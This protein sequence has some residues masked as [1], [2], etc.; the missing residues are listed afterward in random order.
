MPGQVILHLTD[1]HFGSDPD[2]SGQAERKIVLDSLIEEVACLH[3][4]WKPS[5]VCVTGDIGWRGSAADYAL[6]EAWLRRLLD[7]LGLTFADV[8]VCAGNHDIDRH[9][10]SYFSRPATYAEADQAMRVPIAE[11][12]LDCFSEYT[13]FCKRVQVRGYAFNNHT[14]Y[15][16]GQLDHRGIRFVALNSAWFCRGDDDK[17]RLW[18]GL[19]HLRKMEADGQLQKTNESP[20][21]T[22]A[23]VHHS[24]DWW[25]EEETSTYGSR[26]NTR[27]YLGCRCHLILSGHTHDGIRKADRIA[28]AAY[29][30]TGGAAYAGAAHFNSFRLIRIDSDGLTYR[31]LEFDPR[32]ADNKWTDYGTSTKLPFGNQPSSEALPVQTE[33]SGTLDLASLRL[34]SARDARTVVE[35]KSRQIRPV[36]NLPDTVALGVSVRVTG[37]LDRYDAQGRLEEYGDQFVSLPLYEACRQSRRTVLLG[38]LGSG[39]STLGAQFVVESLDKN[40]NGSAFFIP[41]KALQLPEPFRL[42]ELVSACG[43]YIRG[44]II[45]HLSAFDLESRLTSQVEVALVIDGLDE[46]P[47]PRAAS[48]LRQL[49]ALVDCWPNAQVLATG[50]PIELAGISYENWGLAR[51]NR[52]SDATKRAIF[53]AEALAEGYSLPE[54]TERSRTQ[55]SSLKKHPALD[56]LAG[57]PLAARLLSSRLHGT[58]SAADSIGDLLYELL[59]ERLGEWSERDHKGGMA[60]EFETIF[61]TPEDR[62]EVL[63]VLAFVAAGK[64]VSEEEAARILG[65][66]RPGN[67][68]LGKQALAYFERAGLVSREKEV[69]FA[70]HPLREMAAAAAVLRSWLAKPATD[71]SSEDVPWR[72]A[73]FAAAVARRRGQLDQVRPQVQAF[74]DSLLRSSDG[75]AA[76]CMV[77]SE[78]RDHELACA[79][80][81]GVKQLGRKPLYWNRDERFASAQA[82]AHTLHLAGDK[83]FDWFVNAYLDARY[84]ILHAGSEVVEEVLRHWTRFGHQSITGEQQTKLRPLVAPLLV[85]GGLLVHVLPALAIL[86]PDAFPENQRLWFLSALLDDELLGSEAERRLVKFSSTH[87][88]IV[89]DVLCRRAHSSRRAI[90][91]FFGLCPDEK[92]PIAIA[93]ALLR[94]RALDPENLSLAEALHTCVAKVGE[95]QWRCFLRWC[96]SDQESSVGGGA[97]IL[98]HEQGEAGLGLLGTALLNALHDGGHIRRAEEILSGLVGTLGGKGVGWLADHMVERGERNGGHSG[99]WRILLQHLDLAGQDGPTI[100]AGCAAA[101][102]PYLLARHPEVRAGLHRHLTGLRENEFREALRARLSDPNRAM[103]HG[104][105]SILITCDP[106]SEAEALFI[107]VATRSRILSMEHEWESFCLS[108]AFGPGVLEN[109]HSRIGRM[110]RASRAFALAILQRHGVAL[111]PAEQDTLFGHLLELG[112]WNLGAVGGNETGFESEEGFQYL[113]RQLATLP[114]KSAQRVAGLLLSLFVSRLTPE[115]AA[116]CWCLVCSNSSCSPLVLSEQLVRVLQES[117]YRS[118]MANSF[119]AVAGHLGQTSLLE[120]VAAAS[121]DPTR[122]QEVVWELLHELAGL[123]HE[124]D[125]MGQILLDL[126]RDFPEYSGPIGEAARHYLHDPRLNGSGR[127]EIR[128]WLALLTDEFGT[129]SPAELAQVLTTTKWISAS[130]V[131]ALLARLDSVPAE[132]RQKHRAVDCP[133]DLGQER[134]LVPA[135]GELVGKLT[136]WSRSSDAVHPEMCDSIEQS[137]YFGSVP[138]DALDTMAKQ[139]IVGVLSS[140]AIRFCAGEPPSLPSRLALVR[141]RGPRRHPASD[142]CIERLSDMVRSFHGAYLEED[143]TGREKY[144]GALEDALRSD[145]GQIGPLA[146]ELL[147]LRGGL[148]ADLVNAVFEAFAEC[149]D[150]DEEALACG[151]VRWVGSLAPGPEMDAVRQGAERA[152]EL[153]DNQDHER[154]SASF[155]PYAHVVCPLTVWALGGRPSV[156]EIN[157]YWY[158]VEAMVSGR[159][160]IM[161]SLPVACSLDALFKRIPPSVWAS[162]REAGLIGDQPCVASLVG[163]LGGFAGLHTQFLAPV[164]TA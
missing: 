158:G 95:G 25:H 143:G 49:A 128:H 141:A 2:T 109:L 9:R 91:L 3:S 163:L 28:E 26:P 64:S 122:W 135:S 68:Q 18:V 106:R 160:G 5:I 30:L 65:E 22:V 121:V 80:V 105:A 102:G 29:H 23:L 104:A 148:P 48:L 60:N 145:A 85:D 137:L 19:P 34:A 4:E 12:Y 46:V 149:L 94:W 16:L 43:D 74:I 153:L 96:L 98:L 139:G 119:E 67:L 51:L 136:E 126:G 37:Q 71:T 140:E 162:V 151:I 82:I 27:D 150:R 146:A 59:I 130:C 57:T 99:Y 138:E 134:L 129:L 87:R 142:R 116:K 79:A 93:R 124:V 154:S 20:S 58:A 72:I 123:L 8:L 13:N 38:D 42:D 45:P 133:E 107:A 125:D 113:Y 14:S 66:S 36:G 101:V 32:S 132:I 159:P 11:P 53:Q 69:S 55:L 81:D 110:G 114:M 161:R 31:S 63:G 1:L 84:P 86:V 33:T 15:L 89:I 21:P 10:S 76:A 7:R 120:R 77:V 155:P 111:S 17:S 83:G 131:R 127:G 75:V 90:A 54:A 152:I 88:T 6:A 56:E 40:P 92:P 62:A 47:R 41:A 97:A 156:N 115:E 164:N 39:K 100:L 73:A 61:G 24:P 44:Q 147:W 118:L 157:L 144:A 117:D 50:R 35:A 103:R 78:A 108:L 52:L 112:N 70:F